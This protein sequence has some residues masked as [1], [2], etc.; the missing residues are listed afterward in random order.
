MKSGTDN[1]SFVK[2]AEKTATFRKENF[3]Q[4]WDPFYVRTSTSQN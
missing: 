1:W 4:F 3:F 2:D